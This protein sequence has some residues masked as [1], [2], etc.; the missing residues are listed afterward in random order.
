MFR[1][2]CSSRR[3]T[4]WLDDRSSPSRLDALPER[5]LLGPQ[6]AGRVARGEIGR[7]EHL[8]DL[9]LFARL[10]R[11]ALDPFDRLIPRLD[12]PQPKA[13]DQLLG[14]GKGPVDY[15]RLPCGEPNAR[16]LRRRLKPLAREHH[17]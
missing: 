8:A 1:C 12:L 3:R 14:L 17:A 10:E 15:R 7:L 9:D 6:L 4:L 16:A 13:G 2:Y 11:S 5:F